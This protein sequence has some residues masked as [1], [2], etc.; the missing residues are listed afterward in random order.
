MEDDDESMYQGEEYTV[1][2][3]LEISYDIMPAGDYY[4]A[5]CIDDIYG[6]YYI[7]DVADFIIDEDGNISFFEY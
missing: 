7:T 1:A 5:F 2:G 6:D 3:K 4:Y